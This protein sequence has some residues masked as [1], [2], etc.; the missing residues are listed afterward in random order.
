VSRPD[1]LAPLL[2][3]AIAGE[4]PAG[5]ETVGLFFSGGV[6]SL[7]C[8]FAA[9]ALGLRV[10]AYTFRL[11]ARPSEDL[12]YARIAAKLLGWP[13]TVVDVPTDVELVERDALR[14]AREFGCRKKTTFECTWPFLYVVPTLEEKTVVSGVAADGHF[15]VSKKAMIHYREPKTRF[16]EF[17]RG[18]FG[19]ENPA[20]VVQQRKLVEDAGG[21]LIAPYLAGAVFDYLLGF[22][23]NEL[24][25][26]KQKIP[27][28]LAYPDRFDGLRYRRH[29][30]F[31]LVA[32]VPAVF[33]KLLDRPINR[34]SRRRVLDLCRDLANEVDGRPDPVENPH[35]TENPDRKEHDR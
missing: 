11:E 10:H 20:G 35:R 12:Q 34:K 29:A 26:P 2:E 19:D 14:L 9:E 17:R 16:D 8:G 6:D 18:Y 33:E 5:T 27:A 1:G 4:L 21:T 7:S 30:N 23:W 24:N 28:L 25:R 3:D 13:L 32:G 31:Q 22:D 15:G